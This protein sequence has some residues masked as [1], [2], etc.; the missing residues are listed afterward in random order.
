M[1]PLFAILALALL[2]SACAPEYA[3]DRY[4]F[5]RGTAAFSQCVQN[6]VLAQQAKYRRY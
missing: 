2:T 4:G 3:C 5:K 6:E 1:R